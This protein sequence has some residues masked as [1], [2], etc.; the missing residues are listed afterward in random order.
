M[1]E[2]GGRG[3]M[4]CLGSRCRQPEG[5]ACQAARACKMLPPENRQVG[6]ALPQGKLGDC[7]EWHGGGGDPGGEGRRTR[8]E[9]IPRKYVLTFCI[10]IIYNGIP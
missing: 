2:G 8:R 9:K 10:Y 7:P 6:C 4:G 5:D 1:S 3:P